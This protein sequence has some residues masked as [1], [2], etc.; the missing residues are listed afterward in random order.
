MYWYLLTCEFSWR[1]PGSLYLSPRQDATFHARDGRNGVATL[2]VARYN[3]IHF[4]IIHRPCIY[5]RAVL[6]CKARLFVILRALLE[7]IHISKRLFRGLL[8]I[9][10]VG[11]GIFCGV[12]EGWHNGFFACTDMYI[13]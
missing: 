3:A 13:L 7:R 2:V 10:K 11:A 8:R 6:H 12:R 1:P 9:G 4:G 5:S